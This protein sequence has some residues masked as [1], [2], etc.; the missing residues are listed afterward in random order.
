[1]CVLIITY[2]VFQSSSEQSFFFSFTSLLDVLLG[3]ISCVGL[4]LCSHCVSEGCL[5]GSFLMSPS[6]LLRHKLIEK[7]EREI[8]LTELSIPTELRLDSCCV[9]AKPM[10]PLCLSI[11]DS[12]SSTH[13]PLC[14]L[15]DQLLPLFLLHTHNHFSKSQQVH[16]PPLSAGWLISSYDFEV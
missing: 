11:L 4:K 14:T 16:Y 6:P 2:N 5:W 3:C 1:M 8:C 12:L 9:S 7:R 15:Y 13:C 10:V